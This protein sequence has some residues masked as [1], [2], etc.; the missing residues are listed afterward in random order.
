MFPTIQRSILWQFAFAH[1]R[2][3]DI[4]F[5]RNEPP[6][7]NPLGSINP[8]SVGRQDLTQDHRLLAHKYTNEYLTMDL[9]TYLL[10]A[11]LLTASLVPCSS[12]WPQGDTAAGEAVIQS[13]PVADDNVTADT[14][15]PKHETPAA[16]EDRQQDD[17]RKG[18]QGEDAKEVKETVQFL[19][20]RRDKDE[21]P[22]AM[23][24]S[25]TRFVGKNQQGADVAVDLVGAVHV[26]ERDYYDQLNQLFQSY[27]AVLYE[28]VAPEGTRVVPG[29]KRASSNPVSML[30]NVMKNV[31]KLEF[32]LDRID[33]T[34]PN[35]VHADMS[36]QEFSQS[37]KDRG[38]SFLKMFFQ[39]MGQAMA[40]QSNQ[41]NTP[42]DLELLVALVAKD[43]AYRLKRIMAE[44]FENMEGQLSAIGGPDGSTIITQRNKRA[45]A[46]LRGR[47][48]QGK[49]RLAIFY[50]AGHLSDMA[51]RLES[52]FGLRQES[53]RWLVA[54]TIVPPPAA[55]PGAVEAESA[56]APAGAPDGR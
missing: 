46:V 51:E 4:Y 45:L 53:Q 9:R 48:G 44:Q 12:A 18:E 20:I 26:G 22:T 5:T 54:W 36:P 50:G 56:P 42:S 8:P 32:Q 16:A 19:R 3:V 47:L 1:V 39:M 2:W 13:P 33:Y 27:D 55:T 6:V 17:Q 28:L 38:E 25:I 24:T 34:K 35:M 37:M 49:R 15:G 10:L 31:L 29:Q 21:Q 41:K 40:M 7:M 30:Q 43:R 11:S 52:E 14:N 23:E